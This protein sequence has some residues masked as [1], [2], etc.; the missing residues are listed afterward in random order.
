MDLHL[1]GK[2][3][4]ITGGS[5]GIG[6]AIAHG[7]AAEGVQPALCARDEARLR[8][9]RSPRCLFMRS[10]KSRTCPATAS[11][12]GQLTRASASWA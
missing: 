1:T 10:A 12:S 8:T 9:R 2:V 5:A 3:A 7:L 11:S 4:V 6:R